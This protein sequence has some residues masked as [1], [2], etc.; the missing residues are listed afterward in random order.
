MNSQLYLAPPL[1]GTCPICGCEHRA[2]EPH[3]VNSL[4]FKYA[5]HEKHGRFPTAKDACQHCPASIRSQYIH[6]A[7]SCEK[8][9]RKS[10][11]SRKKDKPEEL[12]ELSGQTKL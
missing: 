8:V 5:F 7:E 6:N 10:Y 9:K 11:R 3:N 4:Y 12:Q 2:D 1:P